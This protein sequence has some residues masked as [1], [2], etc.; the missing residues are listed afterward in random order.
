MFR[1]GIAYSWFTYTR[2]PPW[3]ASRETATL[4]EIV[5]LKQPKA[6][7]LN[8]VKD[9]QKKLFKTQWVNLELEIGGDKKRGMK[10]GEGKTESRNILQ[11]SNGERWKSMKEYKGQIDEMTVLSLEKNREWFYR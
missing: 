3:E 5:R 2:L 6:S 4:I 9:K 10:F 7:K 1:K 8:L 11:F